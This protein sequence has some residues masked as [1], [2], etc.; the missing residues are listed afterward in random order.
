MTPFVGARPS[1]WLGGDPTTQIREILDWA[2]YAEELGF[3]VFYVGDRLLAAV[4][5]GENR[6]YESSMLDPFVLLSGVAARTSKIRLATLVAVVPYRHPASLAKITASLDVLSGG[7]FI[8]GA[9]SGWNR[10]ELAMYG[11][12]YATRGKRM[13]E[14]LKL[15][16]RLWDGEA[17]T[18]ATEFWD[19]DGIRVT[20]TPDRAPPIW[21]GSFRPTDIV[22]DWNG[23]I[24]DRIRRAL[25]R[26]GRLADGWVPVLYSGVNQTRMSGKQFAASWDVISEAAE[27]AG[28]DPEKIEI[29]FAHWVAIVRDQ[30]ER[31]ACERVL[32]RF[33][34]GTYEEA[35]NTY[36][37]GTPEE[38]LEQ[39]RS[40]TSELNRIDG[41][42]F[43]PLNDDKTQLQ[44]ISEEIRRPLLAS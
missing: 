34:P 33:F 18:E 16:R 1:G 4:A 3:D 9:G 39:I 5:S 25:S 19:L 28:R 42:L 13:E 12:D 21:L 14:G 40:M 15:V 37:I 36:L 23:E 26:V 43:T 30:A 32:A 35:R 22:P 27:A 29:I 41:Y 8:L 17:I 44:A 7:R 38:I 10:T 6:V 24:D 2:V 11:V 20:P 31:A